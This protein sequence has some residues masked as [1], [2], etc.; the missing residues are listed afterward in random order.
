MS[1]FE[2]YKKAKKQEL[3]NPQ[4]MNQYRERVQGRDFTMPGPEN[5]EIDYDADQLMEYFEDRNKNKEDFEARTDYYFRD[6]LLG[7]SKQQQYQRYANDENGI[8]SAYSRSYGNHYAWKRKSNASNAAKNFRIMNEKMAR[9]TQDDE[10]NVDNYTKYL[11]REEIM[12]YRLKGMIAAAETKS[13]NKVHESYLKG[14]AKLSCN[15]LL[16]EQLLN[17]IQ[18]E[19]DD[20]LKGRLQDKLNGVERK[21]KDAYDEIKNSSPS[22]QESWREVHGINKRTISEKQRE[23]RDTCG[24]FS[25]DATNM[26]LNLETIQ[27]QVKSENT[28][29]PCRIVLKDKAD[30]PI[31]RA[32]IKNKKFNQSYSKARQD[33]DQ[34]ALKRMEEEGIE[35]FMKMHIPT[36]DEL[37]GDSLVKFITGHLREYY[38]MTKLALPY[39]QNKVFGED[40]S[41]RE[42][43][44]SHQDFLK[45][46]FY[47]EA[48]NKYIDF[49][50]RH[51]HL[52]MYDGMGRF[53][54]EGDPRYRFAR[55]RDNG[56]WARQQR[57]GEGE[58]MR[59]FGKLTNAFRKYS[60]GDPVRLRNRI[61]NINLINDNLIIKDEEKNN[62]I[63]D[64]KD[65][66]FD[67]VK[68]TGKV[69][70]KFDK[71]KVMGDVTERKENKKEDKPVNII[72]KEE[73]DLEPLN[74][75]QIIKERET[76]DEKRRKEKRQKFENRKE[77]DDKYTNKI[78]IESKEN[79]NRIN[80]IHEEEDE[81]EL[82]KEEEKEY[83]TIR[84]K[85]SAKLKFTKEDF[86]VYKT[87]VD[88]QKVS[89]SNANKKAVSAGLK[90]GVFAGEGKEYAKVSLAPA[91][92]LKSLRFKEQ[93]T[94]DKENG[95]THRHEMGITPLDQKKLEENRVW[96]K[97]WTSTDQTAAREQYIK[98]NLPKMFDDFKW[99]TVE[100]LSNGTALKGERLF[101]IMD[102]LRR[103]KGIDGLVS[104][105][106][107]AKNIC[108]E[109]AF[110]AKLDMLKNLKNYIT[111]NLRLKRNIDI[112]PEN[113]DGVRL[114]TR[115]FMSETDL[116]G[117][118]NDNLKDYEEKLRLL[119][120]D[121][122]FKKTV[123]VKK[124]EE[125]KEN[126]NK[127]N[128][129]KEEKKENL[130]KINIIN[131]EKK[132]SKNTIDEDR[133][134][135]KDALKKSHDAFVSFK[136]HPEYL[137]LINEANK[138][139]VDGL[140]GKT[141]DRA[142]M[143]MLKFVNFN[144][145][146][147]PISKTDKE[148]HEW[149][150]KWLKTWHGVN[151]DF[152]TMGKMIQENMP[153]AYDGVDSLPPLPKVQV[154]LAGLDK[155]EKEN[156]IKEYR[157][158]LDEWCE[159]IIK[160]DKLKMILFT[161]RKGLSIDNL[162]NKIPG[163]KDYINEEKNPK[164]AALGDT[165]GSAVQYLLLYV[166]QK[167]K[168][169]VDSAD[170]Q[171]APNNEGILDSYAEK[172]YESSILYDQ[173]K[174]DKDMAFDASK[175]KTMEA[176]F[177]KDKEFLQ[178]K[179]QVPEF[180]RKGYDVLK[181]FERVKNMGN[182][183]QY[184]AAYDKAEPT[185]SKYMGSGLSFDRSVSLIIKP[186]IYDK[187]GR[188]TTK[189]MAENEA[190]NMKWLKAWE[191]DDYD[192]REEM[193][194]EYYP[195]IY[196]SVSDIPIPT[197]KQVKNPNLYADV[198]N[199]WIEKKVHGD[200]NNFF[201]AIRR[202]LA[203]NVINKAHPSLANHIKSDKRF[204][205]L[206][207]AV[208]CLSLYATSYLTKQ[209]N[210]NLIDGR[211]R[212]VDNKSTQVAMANMTIPDMLKELTAAV[213]KYGKLKDKKPVP[214][215]KM[216][217]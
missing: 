168:M 44:L 79:Q 31:N 183:P 12:K 203:F 97:L 118:V 205:A 2:E 215:K 201:S 67:K 48:V 19:N 135:I 29:W 216:K 182:R 113:A 64:K 152:D 210:V 145:K 13:K 11:H 139:L 200:S 45:R 117:V 95:I 33:D 130:N 20:L 185:L 82:N 42:Y 32:E 167:Y 175:M 72:N 119:P 35:R 123:E 26:L 58:D 156:V 111:A 199:V 141:V 52:I 50:L 9:Y 101:E 71:V 3:E 85:Y 24:V 103:L 78:N 46:L 34:E 98:E 133:K 36:P 8:T 155:K 194:S 114:Y 105:S 86:L 187:D 60:S 96:I 164:Y 211:D 87:I 106:K 10:L 189:E 147:E 143:H 184:K 56:D 28:Q 170:L 148:N 99:P 204:A 81:V 197:A 62:L 21:I 27:E 102:M 6:A 154:D 51:D 108:N 94:E 59:E 142:V 88:A 5:H 37:T 63:N 206:N 41:L 121:A 151:G 171:K 91:P 89:H 77:S 149:N 76:E 181:R 93:V 132:D 84:S 136:V 150:K 22:V 193:I 174:N 177:Q 178:F 104:M 157:L 192:T 47:V 61:E 75:D 120:K 73:D 115:R 140:A 126:L 74:I 137:K 188:P 54:I 107:T 144:K 90:K 92:L 214:Y 57:F 53:K 202:D 162:K 18:K 66:K 55:R 122:L 83:R 217:K 198:I 159:K 153:H 49:T 16:K 165:L 1:H 39:Y 38:E 212:V 110:V 30:G 208:N 173:H 129:I 15:M 179:E 127:I 7:A 4:A 116:K 180:T 100:E 43:A 131:E 138:Y 40:G 65:E 25:S 195:N 207:Q 190:W 17:L 80:I 70:E 14:R 112:D 169:N 69:T 176:E 160:E 161:G 124:E 163:I 213:A 191:D 196:D 158:Q 134:T 109:P 186:V 23:Y 128:I 68:V 166:P 172:L 125:K 209:Y 146:G